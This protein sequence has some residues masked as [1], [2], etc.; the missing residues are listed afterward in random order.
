MNQTAA[1]VKSPDSQDQGGRDFAKILAE[2]QQAAAAGRSAESAAPAAGL[3]NNA[4]TGLILAN[5]GLAPVAGPQA[6]TQKQL[7]KTLDQM[8]SYSA[9][10]GD[11][12]RTLKD[13]APLADG[14]GQSADR[15]S[16]LSRDLPES[17]P[18][19]GLSNEAAVLATVEAMKFKRGDYV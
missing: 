16:Q 9:A 14:L 12:G 3:E 15:L 2:Q 19:K 13:I 7:E 8:D 11:L 6:Q 5:L 4:L 18:L 1:P 10:L 17:D